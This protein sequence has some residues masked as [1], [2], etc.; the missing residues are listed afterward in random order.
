MTATKYAPFFTLVQR[1]ATSPPGVWFLGRTLHHFDRLILNLSGR[2]LTLTGLFTGLPV[3]MLTTTG[4]R[5]GRPRTV[6]LLYIRDPADPT[7]FALIASNWGR[8]R[9]PAWYY[10]LKAD[11]RA[12]GDLGGKVGRYVAHEAVG[13]TYE[14]FWQYAADLYPGYLLYRQ[15]AGGRRIP[16]MIMTPAKS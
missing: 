9:Y 5:S 14:R 11:P 2:R 10:N 3:V 13:G 15:R 6:P 16:I 7:T 4:A 1:L 8:R 12:Q